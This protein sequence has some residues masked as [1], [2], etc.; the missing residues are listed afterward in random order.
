MK[1]SEALE[2]VRDSIRRVYGVEPTDAMV[3]GAAAVAFLETKYGR[4]GQFGKLAQKG[5]FNWGAH[6]TARN[7]DGSCKPGTAPGQ[8]V[9]GVCYYVFDNDDDAA[10]DYIKI[11]KRVGVPLDQGAKAQAA[12]MRKAGYYQGYNWSDGYNEA[13][14]NMSQAKYHPTKEEAD[15]ANIAAYASALQSGISYFQSGKDADVGPP[16]PVRK[17]GGGFIGPLPAPSPTPQPS[18][19]HI[20]DGDT[21]NFQWALDAD[22]LKSVGYGGG[23]DAFTGPN[24]PKWIAIVK[25]FQKDEGLTVDGIMGPK[26]RAK[27]QQI[28]AGVAKAA[29][30]TASK[31]VPIIGILAAI[32]SAIFGF[33]WL[34]G[35]KGK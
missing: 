28:A 31:T 3:H 29:A 33:K 15:A 5:M 1:H 4:I 2:I 34:L 8:D 24:D 23:R 20:D 26:T 7:K 17:D 10:D 32:G 16:G 12:A 22:F 13:V 14:K 21:A 25:Q 6:E 27:A 30:A 19:E 9:G 11:L 35:R 18:Q